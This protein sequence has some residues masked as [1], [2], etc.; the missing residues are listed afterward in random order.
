MMPWR[1]ADVTG[2]ACLLAKIE[3]RDEEEGRC[4]RDSQNGGTM[5][6]VDDELTACV[7]THSQIKIASQMA[8]SPTKRKAGQLHH[9]ASSFASQVPADRN[10]RNVSLIGSELL[11]H[12]AG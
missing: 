9:R 8:E 3:K 10:K 11:R 4:P 12:F 5:L 7:L 6:Q 1:P 2:W